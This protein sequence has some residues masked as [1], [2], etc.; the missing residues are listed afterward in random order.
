[1]ADNNLS[2]GL[3]FPILETRGRGARLFKAKPPWTP[4]NLT[5]GVFYMPFTAAQNAT[6]VDLI[7]GNNATPTATLTSGTGPNGKSALASAA[8]GYLTLASYLFAGNAAPG[9]SLWVNT[10]AGGSSYEMVFGCGSDDGDRFW[11]TTPGGVGNEQVFL[12]VNPSYEIL[13]N[14]N[15][16][17][18]GTL[19]HY[20]IQIWNDYIWLFRNWVLQ[21]ATSAGG[22]NPSQLHGT[23]LLFN[24][25]SA[26]GPIFKGTIAEPA[27]TKGPMLAWGGRALYDAAYPLPAK[28]QQGPYYFVTFDGSEQQ[29][30]SMTLRTL[31]GNDGVN[32]IELP[33]QYYLI[34]GGNGTVRDPNG[35][36]K[37][38][39]TWICYTNNGVSDGTFVTTTSFGV[40][41]TSDGLNWQTATNIVPGVANTE[42]IFAPSRF[43]DPSSG[44]EYF[45]WANGPGP[46]SE[47]AIDLQLYYAQITDTTGYTTIG[48]PTLL[49]LTGITSVY[50]PC[51]VYKAGTYYLFFKQGTVSYCRLATASSLAGP[52]TVVYDGS[53]N[54]LGFGSAEGPTVYLANG[55]YKVTFDQLDGSGNPTGLATMNNPAGDLVTWQNKQ[56]IEVTSYLNTAFTPRH[57]CVIPVP[58]S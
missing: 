47:P 11:F 7:G 12:E 50:D 6:Q 34:S 51:L 46:T 23:S 55:E 40:A 36:L 16:A 9:I 41:Y 30:T 4:K 49:S 20:F 53:T 44:N 29:Q 17:P 54:A 48:S 1:M 26:E 58:T 13:S 15:P 42:I 32:F 19:T 28:P 5:N 10:A 56:T 2:L 14:T 27:I 39:K 21:V 33:Q 18:T 52:W 24:G 57:G 22:L 25:Q 31:R 37:G 38:G 3:P 45:V 43:L 8:S 35:W